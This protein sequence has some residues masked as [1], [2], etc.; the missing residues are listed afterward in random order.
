MSS[1]RQ[2]LVDAIGTRLKADITTVQGRVWCRRKTPLQTTE[3]PALLFEDGD[4]AVNMAIMG[5]RDHVLTVQIVAC[6]KTGTSAEQARALLESIAASI[7]SD[8]TFGGLACWTEMQQHAINSEHD[9]D[10]LA[11]C[12]LTIAIT[13]RT[14]PGAT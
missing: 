13:Y 7:F 5:V 1:V 3:L 4:A 2:Q 10:L 8:P 6:T 14:A 9:G 12:Q 11:A